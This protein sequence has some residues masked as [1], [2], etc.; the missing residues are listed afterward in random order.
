VIIIKNHQEPLT[1]VAEERRRGL[2]PASV[3]DVGA[4]TD[5]RGPLRASL[6]GKQF[7]KKR[8][9]FANLKI[10]ATPYPPCFRGV[11]DRMFA[12]FGHSRAPAQ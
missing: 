2:A 4:R 8:R 11:A 6:Q 9:L 5:S 1:G 12:I 7:A 10:A 3:A